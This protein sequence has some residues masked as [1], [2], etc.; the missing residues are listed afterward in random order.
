MFGSK[1]VFSSTFFL[2]ILLHSEGNWIAFSTN[3]F[4]LLHILS[5][6]NCLQNFYQDLEVEEKQTYQHDSVDECK[7]AEA[8]AGGWRYV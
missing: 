6:A 7:M 8:E 5:Q 3:V 1:F 4:Y 2:E